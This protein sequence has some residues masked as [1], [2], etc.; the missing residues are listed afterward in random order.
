MMEFTQEQLE[1]SG[2]H[3]KAAPSDDWRAYDEH[4][5]VPG[6]FEFD[7]LSARHPDLYHAFARSTIGL[8]NELNRLVHLSGLEVVDVGAGTGRST[9]EAA[10]KAKH[11]TAVDIYESVVCFGNARV[12]QAGLSNVTYLRGDGAKLPFANH[13]FDAWISSWAVPWYPEAYRVLKPDGYLFVM[14]AAPGALCGELTSI[15]A[16]AYPDLIT[17]ITPADQFDAGFPDDDSMIQDA[18][19]KGLP[20]T[21]PVLRHDFTYISDYGDSKEA[22]AILGRLYGPKARRYMLDRQKCTLAWRLRIEVARI[23]K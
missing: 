6:Y 15:L 8:M 23:K 4:H 12:D 11:V 7:W 16:D 2:Y 5:P 19:W 18:T 17:E 21:F 3:L 14:G 20:V 9:L 10:R 1:S 22:A 13:S